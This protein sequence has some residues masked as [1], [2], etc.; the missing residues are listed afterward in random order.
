MNLVKYGRTFHL[1][2]SPGA[3]DDDKVLDS[4]AHFVGH[5]VVV[6]EKMDGENTTVY[7]TGYTHARSVDSKSHPSRDW[8]KANAAQ[9][10]W[11]IPSGWRVCGENLYARHSI[12]YTTLPSYFMM[13]GVFDENDMALDWDTV[14]SLALELQ[15]P[16]VPVLYRGPW[17]E[18]N[19]RKL[20]T[21]ESQCGG[22][23][24]GYV[25]RLARSFRWEESAIAKFVRTNHVQTDD[26]WMHKAVIP[27][28]LSQC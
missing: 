13:F 5:E 23:Q 7:P 25:V 19:I 28:G 1:P 27:N 9:W 8:L 21:G 12:S 6:T 14:E 24:E 16:T 10:A 20:F 22:A 15:V 4:V 2:W 26:H 11:K 18:T 17:D 3:T